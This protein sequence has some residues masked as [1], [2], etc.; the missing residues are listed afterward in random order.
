MR[1]R[2]FIG[3][4]AIL[5]LASGFMA[6]G[7]IAQ[8]KTIKEQLPGAWTLLLADGVKA[9]GTHVP[10][11]GPNPIGTLMVS[12][13]GR[14]A[15]MVMRSDLKPFASNNPAN[16]TPAESKAVFGGMLA[17]FGTYTTDEAAKTLNFRIEG[18]T[19]PNAANTSLKRMVIAITD[20]VLT[21]NLPLSPEL[22]FDHG[23]TVWKKIK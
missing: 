9:D 5:V 8:Q 13:T 15:L 21:Y 18:S 1:K 6:G 16:A 12:P 20:D 10:N 11:Y 22:G 19:F 7:A 23:E 17:H 2:N 3:L 4:A 14:Y